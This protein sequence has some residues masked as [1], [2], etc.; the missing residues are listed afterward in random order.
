MVEVYIH[1][2]SVLIFKGETI[3]KEVCI[4]IYMH[5]HT[6]VH[7]CIH[8]HIC[9]YMYIYAC[10]CICIYIYAYVYIYVY[11]C[12]CIYA[13]MC[14]YKCVCRPLYILK[15]LSHQ[16]PQTHS[17]IALIALSWSLN[18]LHLSLM[19]LAVSLSLSCGSRNFIN[20]GHIFFLMNTKNKVERKY[21]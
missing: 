3:N 20:R 6:H 9:I 18:S 21:N 4:H 11:A 19:P 10:I 14:I 13:H 5:T 1:R 15:H 16:K 2:T 7:I 8:M 17:L 12:I